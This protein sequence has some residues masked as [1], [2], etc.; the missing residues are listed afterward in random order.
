MDIRSMLV[1]GGVIGLVVALVVKFLLDRTPFQRV[2]LAFTL[3][4]A[5]FFACHFWAPA[6]TILQL[7]VRTDS[8]EIRALGSFWFAFILG[9][10][11]GIFMIKSWMRNWDPELPEWFSKTVGGLAVTVVALVLLAQVVTC[12]ELAIPQVKTAFASGTMP[13]RVAQKVSR[14]TLRT[15]SRIGARVCRLDPRALVGERV[16]PF[17]LEC[18][19]QK[20]PNRPAPNNRRT[21]S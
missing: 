13:A 14:F 11:P 18:L 19:Q 9:C 16:P 5:T 8:D 15:Y 17:V 6:L 21:G 20:A 3:V 10:L 12:C 1:F 4:W 2:T 7:V